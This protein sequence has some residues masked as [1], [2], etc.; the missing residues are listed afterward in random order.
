MPCTNLD[1]P[2]WYALSETHQSF[3]LE[4][5][6]TKFYHPDYAPFG[7]FVQ[8]INIPALENYSMMLDSFFIVG[9]KPALPPHLSF[10]KE[11]V[12]L[13]MIR[14][15]EIATTITE[16]IVKLDDRYQDALYKLVTEVQPGY[17]RKKTFMLGEYFGIF[18]ANRLVAVAGERM[19]ME[20]FIEVSAIVTDPAYTGRGFAKQLTAHCVNNI[21]SKECIPFLHVAAHN[22]GAI[23]LYEKLGFKTR[24][25]ISFWHINTADKI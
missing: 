14:E 19:K 15:K 17:F 4:Y 9:E 3:G 10:K 5:G 23:T 7:A 6:D 24:R 18:K 12:C 2:V 13:Q 20:G 25:K 11:L 1:N 16:D 22:T 8:S 21:F